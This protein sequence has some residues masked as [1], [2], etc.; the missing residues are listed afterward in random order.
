[1]EVCP[2]VYLGTSSQFERATEA[3][4]ELSEKFRV[5][6]GYAG[7][8]PDQLEA[9]MEEGAWIVLPATGEVLF[10]TPVQD[11][12]ESLAPPTLPQPSMN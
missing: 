2:G 3:P 12:W 11:L 8:G 9:E 6:T 5:F 4:T 1:M 7:W 10:D